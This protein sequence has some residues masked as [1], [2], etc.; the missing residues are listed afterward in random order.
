L[1]VS[2]EEYGRRFTHPLLR[3]FL[4]GSELA[5]L[6]ALA[7]VFSLAWMSDRNA[8]YSIGGS[9]AIIGLIVDN[10]RNLG[11][12]LRLG[13]RVERILVERDA[14]VGVQLAGGETIAAD[15]VIS[16]ADGHATIYDLLGGKYSDKVT[17]EIFSRLQTFSSYLQVSLGVGHELSQQ[18]AYVIRR[19]DSP[20]MVDPSTQ[21]GQLSFRFF[22]FD[23]T[24]APPGKTAVTCFL[25]TRNFEFWAQLRQQ[26]LAQYQAEKHR[27]AAAVIAVLEKRVTDVRQAIEVIDVSTPATVIRYTGNWKGSMEGWLLTP[28]TGFRPL[29]RTLPG[30][31]QFVMTGQW[32]MPGGGLPSGLITA[33]SAIQAVCKQDRV[34]FAARQAVKPGGGAA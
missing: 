33:R 20:L 32:V 10:L 6:S 12:R 21:L 13:A 25:P 3:S 28:S 24:F 15:W 31:R 2:I 34:P 29:R 7:L 5:Q 11:G 8:G 16:A 4:G 17:D 14:A 30:L 22:H 26:D 18:P 23:P 1:S 9:Q 19:L 27:V